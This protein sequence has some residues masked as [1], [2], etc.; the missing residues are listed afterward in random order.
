M[1]DHLKEALIP[2]ADAVALVPGRRSGQPVAVSTLYRWC[3]NGV[4]GIRL[5]SVQ[6]GA[7]TLTSREAIGRFFA[8]L[9]EQRERA[10]GEPVSRSRRRGQ[11]V[12][13]SARSPKRQAEIDAAMSLAKEELA[14]R[15]CAARTTT[16]V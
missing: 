11:I 5:E 8:S 4:D 15:P 16:P 1:I 12:S 9:T 6:V 3:S 14:P 2:L 7:R 13:A 10:F